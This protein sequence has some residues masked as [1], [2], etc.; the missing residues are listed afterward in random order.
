MDT[1]ETTRLSQE[2][3]RQGRDAGWLGRKIGYSY[4][5]T[6]MVSTGRTPASDR[7]WA[8]AAEALGVE[9]GSIRDEE[10]VA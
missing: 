3:K 9:V 6:W 10:R 1:V 2:L 7:F 4:M 8:L 5:H